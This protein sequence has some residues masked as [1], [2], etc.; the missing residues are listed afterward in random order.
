LRYSLPENESIFNPLFLSYIDFLCYV[1]INSN[2]LVVHGKRVLREN[3][4]L[5]F[6]TEVEED[7]ES[8]IF[9]N[10]ITFNQFEEQGTYYI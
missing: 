6:L 10:I 3:E 1:D 8:K 9:L 2:N 7:D 4:S 5:C